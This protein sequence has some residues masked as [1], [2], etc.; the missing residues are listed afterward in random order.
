M[1]LADEKLRGTQICEGGSVP[2]DP[3]A[4]LELGTKNASIP[5]KPRMVP[6]KITLTV[7]GEYTTERLALRFESKLEKVPP[8]LLLEEFGKQTPPAR[9]DL[10]DWTITAV[11]DGSCPATSTNGA[12]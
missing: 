6:S 1:E 5:D 7:T 2:E 12:P 8:P 3:V 10:T 9:P 11:R 4:P